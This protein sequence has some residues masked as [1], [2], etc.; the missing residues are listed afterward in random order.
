MKNTKGPTGLFA[1]AQGYATHPL[2]G[3]RIQGGEPVTPSDMRRLRAIVAAQP[4]LGPDPVFWQRFYNLDREGREAYLEAFET[5]YRLKAAK[6]KIGADPWSLR[7]GRLL[8]DADR[9]LADA[10]SELKPSHTSLS[11]SV[12]GIR[13]G[14][15][16]LAQMASIPLKFGNGTPSGGTMPE[17]WKRAI[18]LLILAGRR[19]GTL[20]DMLADGGF[21]Q[22]VTTCRGMAERAQQLAHAAGRYYAADMRAVWAA[23]EGKPPKLFMGKSTKPGG[24]MRV[25]SAIRY[26]LN[27][28][29]GAVH[30]TA[31]LGNEAPRALRN[32]AFQM[33][34][35]IT[36]LQQ[37]AGMVNE[38]LH[39]TA[40]RLK[41]AQRFVDHAM[42]YVNGINKADIP[43]AIAAN[44]RTSQL[45]LQ[46]AIQEAERWAP[47]PGVL[48][49]HRFSKGAAVKI[50]KIPVP[51]GAR[52]HIPPVIGDRFQVNGRTFVI[53]RAYRF[54]NAPAG[55][56]IRRWSVYAYLL[57]GKGVVYDFPATEDGRLG[58]GTSLGRWV[59]L[60]P[61]DRQKP[62]AEYPGVLSTTAFD[63]SAKD[64]QRF[65][66]PR[67]D[68]QI[69][70]NNAIGAYSQHG[71]TRLSPSM[72]ETQDAIN[73]REFMRGWSEAMR[74][75]AREA[76][77][78]MGEG[79]DSAGGYLVPN[80]HGSQPIE[81]LLPTGK[82]KRK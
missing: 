56:N 59:T 19:L 67:N 20:A 15:S 27:Y 14:A 29:G 11:T 72:A 75:L 78:A 17:R 10:N 70:W 28:A 68:Y 35:A 54:A 1:G 42:D 51:P 5:G 2:T 44:F 60:K 62:Y 8:T 79:M 74:K 48:S 45:Y 22:A 18:N 76:G 77:K 9:L 13:V 73:K 24:E 16:M 65:P 39:L 82:S 4:R 61:E 53:Q 63:K 66:A 3:R 38:N 47:A 41:T 71:T 34:S 64:I 12:S 50:N 21:G 43:P 40:R 26:A 31:K 81:M 33:E 69:G 52:I 49:T 57:G 25:L 58:D 32:T 55:A 7:A 23:A 36:L 46:R 37:A 80:E 6:A 30:Q